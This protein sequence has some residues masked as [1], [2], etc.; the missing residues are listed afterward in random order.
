M[1]TR[2]KTVEYA[3]P[4]LTTMS[5]NT[6]TNLTQITLYLPESSKTFKNVTITMSAMMNSTAV[7]NINTSRSIGLR[8]DAVAYSSKTQGSLANSGED[9][10]LVQHEDFTS[11]F[12]SNW[13]TETSKTMD[14][15][16]RLD[17]AATTSSWTNICVSIAIT[18]EYDDASA[19]QI[20]TIRIPLD[21]P[22]TTLGSAKGGAIATIPNLS[23]ELPEASKVF[24][25]MYITMQGNSAHDAAT[26]FTT[27]FQL[28]NT[29]AETSGNWEGLSTTAYWLRYLWKVDAVLD[30]ANTMSFYVWNSVATKI[31]HPQIWLTVTYEFNAAASNDMFVSLMVPLTTSNFSGILDGIERSEVVLNIQ[32]TGIVSKQLA[33]F[34]FWTQN[35]SLTGSVGMRLGEGSYLTYTNNASVVGGSVGCMIRN[36]S[37]Y[38]LARGINVLKAYNYINSQTDGLGLCGYAILNYTCNKPSLGYGAANHTVFNSVFAAPTN[39]FLDSL[40]GFSIFNIPDADFS[41]NSIGINFLFMTSGTNSL[42]A[43]SLLL[44]KTVGEGGLK[45]IPIDTKLSGADPEIGAFSFHADISNF[46]VRNSAEVD[47]TRLSLSTTRRFLSKFSATTLAYGRQYLTIYLTYSSISYS[48]SGNI[49]ESNGGTVNLSLFDAVTNQLLANSSRVGNGAYSMKCFSNIN[50]VYVVAYEDGTHLGRSANGTPT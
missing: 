41:I 40:T 19:T 42:S 3:M 32:E 34:Y 43:F 6:L 30:T 5:D 18:Y 36:D 23:T 26:D 46:L 24:R 45:W 31:A 11:Y 50:N 48:V 1:T 16:V 7:A 9:I 4:V 38:S 2:L 49:S 21:A 17:S 47:S 14:V 22:I 37:A 20:K 15:Q 29:T 35:A 8:L 13:T 12:Q 39:F 44:E 28:D 27:T 33:I 10:F 25:N